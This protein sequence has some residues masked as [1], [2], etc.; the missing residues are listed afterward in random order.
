MLDREDENNKRKRKKGKR[1]GGEPGDGKAII[2]FDDV[3][4]DLLVE[5]SENL[6][7]RSSDAGGRNVERHHVIRIRNSLFRIAT[8]AAA[9]AV[10]VTVEGVYTHPT[11]AALHRPSHSSKS[12]SQLISKGGRR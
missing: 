3:I 6:D 9:A 1:L 5:V 7:E 8:A 2:R 11:S 12:Q 4:R 10:F